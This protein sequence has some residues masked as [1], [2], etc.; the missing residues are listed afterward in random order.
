MP[1]FFDGQPA[2]YS[3]FPPTDEGKK[4]KLGNFFATLAAPPKT[5]GRIPPLLS[6]LNSKYS[7]GG[8]GFTGWGI[9]G[10]C[11][12][13]KIATLIS[14]QLAGQPLSFKAA[15]QAH[16]AMLDAADA[17]GLTVPHAMLA[18]RDEPSDAVGKFVAAL[19]GPGIA[20]TYPT[21]NHGWMAA[22]SNLQDPAV[23][24]EYKRGY[25]SVVK[26]LADFL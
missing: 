1:D 23:V 8:K 7:S 24:R 19:K 25:G 2:D 5:L 3:W 13:G 4:A 14:K 26:F 6:E 18:S 11:W 20:E 21:M 15:L 16:P 17:E 12:G 22:R 10:F 9:V